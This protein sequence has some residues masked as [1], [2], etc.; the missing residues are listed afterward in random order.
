MTVKDALE[1]LLRIL[2]EERLLSFTD[3][4][5]VLRRLHWDEPKG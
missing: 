2:H 4:E 3:K 5:I 1:E